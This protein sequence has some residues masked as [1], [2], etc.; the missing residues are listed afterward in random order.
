MEQDKQSTQ[1]TS[2]VVKNKGP[3]NNPETPMMRLPECLVM[4]SE[5]DDRYDGNI[6]LKYGNTKQD[7]LR[8]SYLGFNKLI[9]FLKQPENIKIFNEQLALEKE[10]LSGG[11][12]L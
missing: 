3:D 6:G 11:S 8:I 12:N 4:L 10:K 2:E 1:K 9:G 7:W 5:A